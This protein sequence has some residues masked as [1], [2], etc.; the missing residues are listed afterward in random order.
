MD[1]PRF[2]QSA[3]R[4]AEIALRRGEFPVGCALV[5]E[6][7]VLLTASRSGTLG[8]VP[9]EMDH[10]EMLPLRDLEKRKEAVDRSRLSLY[11][12][13]E[14]CLMCF[15]AILLSGIGRLVWAYEDV[16]GGGTRLDR[17]GLSPLYRDNPIEVVPGVSRAESLRLFRSFFSRP[18]AS[19]WRD[20]LLARYT[21]ER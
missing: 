11:C 1:D 9:S 4:E 12:T 6:G 10:A 8:P 19:Y 16:M 3:L 21:L 13:L 18:G 15:G 14:P 5:Q 7:R 17:G 2:M 20:S